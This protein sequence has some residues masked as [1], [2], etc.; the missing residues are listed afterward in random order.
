MGESHHLETNVF[1]FQM[2]DLGQKQW[3]AP[4]IWANDQ[5]NSRNR[6]PGQMDVL[7]AFLIE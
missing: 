5:G 1:A 7:P 2:T 6:P 4:L 3:T